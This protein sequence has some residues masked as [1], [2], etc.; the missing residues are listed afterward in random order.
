MVLD[1]RNAPTQV[2]DVVNTVN[3]VNPKTFS[4]GNTEPSMNFKRFKACVETGHCA[5]FKDEGTAR[6]AKKFVE[7][8]RNDTASQQCE[9]TFLI[10][11]TI[12][13]IIGFALMVG[14][15]ASMNTSGMTSMDILVLGFIPTLFLI[16]ILYGRLSY[17][18]APTQA[19]GVVHPANSVEPK[20]FEHGNTELNSQQCDKCVQTGYGASLKEE[21]TVGAYR[22]LYELPGNMVA[23]Y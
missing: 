8:Y 14:F 18:T 20:L 2:I 11:S 7:P 15:I 9:V 6:T 21:G 5:S 19:I 17:M 22:K 4:H 13:G 1:G 12:V 16:A 10:I 3:S 23:A